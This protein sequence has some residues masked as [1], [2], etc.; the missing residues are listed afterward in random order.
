MLLFFGII[1]IVLGPDY[2][3][4]AKFMAEGQSFV[5]YILETSLMFAVYLAILQLGVRTFVAELTESFQR[6][7]QY[8]VA[9]G[10]YRGS[11]SRRPLPLGHQMQLRSAF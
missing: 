11:I 7:L 9:R 3:V 6:D 10:L 2:L 8:M 4:Q 5:F 1:L